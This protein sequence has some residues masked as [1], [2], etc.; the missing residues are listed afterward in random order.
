[1]S[2]FDSL[3]LSL[4]WLSVSLCL[5]LGFSV[6]CSFLLCLCFSAASLS[7]TFATKEPPQSP[8]TL[9]LPRESSLPRER[10][11][12]KTG[13]R[14]KLDALPPLVWRPLGGLECRPA[15]GARSAGDARAARDGQTSH[16]S[17]AARARLLALPLGSSKRAARAE[18]STASSRGAGREDDTYN[19]EQTVLSSAARERD[20]RARCRLSSLR[21]PRRSR[22]FGC[23]T[24]PR[25]EH[26][27]APRRRARRV[28]PQ[29]MRR[30]CAIASRGSMSEQGRSA[31][32]HRAACGWARAVWFCLLRVG[33]AL[34]RRGARGA[35]LAR[36]LTRRG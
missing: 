17:G 8:K 29:S 1:M 25:G 30:Q 32:E 20:A 35:L 11:K 10:E 36:V 24:P 31:R 28:A 18:R 13:E 14:W 27:A 23:C 15:G 16:R 3:C 5:C 9:S 26:A 4:L 6:W 12:R 7:Q 19:L 33:W 21:V 2:L 34:S 22:A